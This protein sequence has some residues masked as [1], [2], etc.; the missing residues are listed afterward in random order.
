MRYAIISDLH[1]N[2]QAFRA[3]LADI[4]SA[5]VDEII[6]L[7]DVVGYGPSPAEV[8][9]LAYS[10]VHHFVLGN[11]DAVIARALDPGCFNDSARKAIEWTA[12]QLD[13]KA[14][15]FFAGL[16][17]VLDGGSF[18]CVHGEF[19]DPPAFNYLIEEVDALAS[20]AAA[21]QARILFAGHTHVPGLFVIGGSG[22][23]HVLPP[24]D[25]TMEAG[26]RYIVNTGA[27]GQPRDGDARAS[28]VLFDAESGAVFFRK[29]PFDIEGYRADLAAAGL[30]QGAGFLAVAEKRRQP[31]LREQ[32]D[33]RPPRRTISAPKPE[34]RVEKLEAALRHERRNVARWRRLGLLALLLLAASG[35]VVAWAMPK[36]LKPLPPPPSVTYAALEPVAESATAAGRN[37][38]AEPEAGGGVVSASHRLRSWSVT[39][40]DPK[41]QNVDV[42]AE[43]AT[44]AKGT[45]GDAKDDGVPVFVLESGVA[46]AL[47]VAS[48][49]V[50]A[51][52][53]V[54][55]T[56]S[57]QFR[58][59]GMTGGWVEL[60]LL[61]RL[62]D[63]TEKLLENKAVKAEASGRWATVRFTL[64]KTAR[65][66]Q[67]GQIRLAVR[68]EFAGTVR[69]RKC[70]LLLCE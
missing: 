24:Q 39:V 66:A 38:L 36:A 49:P 31:P 3:V 52:K 65:L 27:V 13:A 68:G 35:A 32:L 22:R 54:R 30:P 50:P 55:F 43:S 67:A 41:L 5:G 33:F 25:F 4:E 45:A 53:G 15:G 7:G 57:A 60:A 26:K 19:T 34:Y 48:A 58:T 42:R 56:A 40:A 11:H 16:P 23:A 59:E 12:G 14:R 51:E 29:T 6:C 63:G 69:V 47:A 61:E 70:A 21:P 64:G 18:R 62:P 8:L 1:A 44:E 2:R 28:W 37:L 20:W 9:S 10:R 46:K 17:L